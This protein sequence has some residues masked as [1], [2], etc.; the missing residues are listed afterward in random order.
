MAKRKNKKN[1]AKKAKPVSME[2]VLGEPAAPAP[3][4]AN[5]YPGRKYR[6]YM[7]NIKHK[8]DWFN[9]P[10]RADDMV[11]CPECKIKGPSDTFARKYREWVRKNKNN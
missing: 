4:A 10:V 5:V 8:L 3:M 2:Y 6:C 11:V 1:V 9:A 7:F